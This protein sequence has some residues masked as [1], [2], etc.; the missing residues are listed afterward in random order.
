M[1]ADP[2]GRLLRVIKLLIV[3]GAQRSEIEGLKW[4]K[5]DFRFGVLRGETRRTGAT[6]IPL[7]RAALLILEDQSQ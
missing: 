3:A 4:T 7:A 6:I 1:S 5:V 2:G